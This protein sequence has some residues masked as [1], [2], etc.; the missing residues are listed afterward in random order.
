MVVFAIVVH[1]VPPLIDCSHLITL[2]VLPLNVTDPL[3]PFEH[4]VAVPLAVPPTEAGLTVIV[5]NVDVSEHVP[6]VTTAQYIDVVVIL[7]YVWLVPVPLSVVHEEPPL[8]ERNHF[9]IVPDWPLNVT[10]PLFEVAHTVVAPV[11][12]PPNTGLTVIVALEELADAQTPLS[13]TARYIVVWLRFVYDCDVVVLAMVVH[14][15]PL[16]ID[17]SHRI[18]FPV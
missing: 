8:V 10:V 7:V 12:V 11:V 4:T 15:V 6:F 9:E 5:V 1:V 18:T 3:L 2:P 17:C 16:L 14:V 13:T